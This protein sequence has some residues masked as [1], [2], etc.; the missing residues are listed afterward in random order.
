MNI[1]E[2]VAEGSVPSPA[3]GEHNRFADRGQDDGTVSGVAAG[4]QGGA[5]Q[6][7]PAGG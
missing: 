1:L 5:E 3:S 6:G 2:Q 4:R 7:I